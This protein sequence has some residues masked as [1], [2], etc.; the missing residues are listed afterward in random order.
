[1]SEGKKTKRKTTN[2]GNNTANTQDASY[3]VIES[4]APTARCSDGKHEGERMLPVRNFYLNRGGK[5]VQGACIVCQTN[6]RTECTKRCRNKFK[7]KTHEEMNTMYITTYGPTKDCSVCKVA[8]PPAEF[9]LSIGMECGLHNQCIQCSTGNS[10][11]NGGLRDFIFMPDKDGIKYKKKD[12]CE[13]CKGTDKLAVDHILPIA[14]GGTDC[15]ANK[16]TLCVHCNSTKSD[17]IDSMAKPEFLSARYKDESLDFSDITALSCKLAKKVYD[18][19]QEHIVNA[20]LEQITNSITAYAKLHNMGHKL[21]RI[22]GMIG[23]VFGKS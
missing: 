10:Q 8:K 11:G 2:L 14:K 23:A 18:F 9:G 21:D 4:K 16:Q 1:M 12:K 7:G 17:T 5:K 3:K 22:V 13:K 6:R 15:I 19:K 20:T